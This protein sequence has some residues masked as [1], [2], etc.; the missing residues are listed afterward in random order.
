MGTHA[1]LVMVSMA[2]RSKKQRFIFKTRGVCTPEIHF[3]INNDIITDILFVGGGC[4]GFA[5]LASRLLNNRPVDEVIRLVD[6]I[7][8]R[9]NTSCPDQLALA[10]EAFRTGSLSPVDSINLAEEPLDRTR[11]GLI[12]DLAGTSRGLKKV[13]EAAA[14]AGAETIF[15]LGNVTGNSI[16]NQQTI[17][18]IRKLKITAVQGKNDWE[19]A[20]GAENPQFPPLDKKER[21]WL[22][23]LPQLRVFFLG[24]KK[25]VA[26]FGEFIQTLPGYS[27][28]EPYALEMNMTCGLTDFMRDESVFPALEAMIPQFQAD[29][30]LFGQAEAWGHWHLAGKEIIRVGPFGEPE[31]PTWGLIESIAGNLRFKLMSGRNHHGLYG[32]D[33]AQ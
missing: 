14:Q 16:H 9:N 33:N 7:G 28:F 31:I 29:I 12:G 6:G 10:L 25:G 8:C 32:S 27:D 19:Y 18:L 17:A 15:C 24:G 11:I 21:D 26:F 20:R 3:Q 4:T 30:I 1:D 13:A 23:R 22:G 5:N 2:T